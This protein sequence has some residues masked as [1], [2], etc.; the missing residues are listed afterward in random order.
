[1]N[2][3]R[4]PAALITGA[5][6]GLGYSMSR[7]LARRG[8]DL[9]LV[10]LPG[11]G[12][13]SLCQSLSRSYSIRAKCIEI[14]MISA[15]APAR[16]K[17]IT[18]SE[19]TSI[20]ILINNVGIGYGGEI[21]TYKTKSVEETFFLN[22]ISATLMTN[23][24][25]DDLKSF[26]KSH[27]LNMGSFSGFTPMPYKSMY[28]AS[29]AYIFNFSISVREELHG[30]GVS[31]SVAMPGPVKTNRKVCERIKSSGKGAQVTALEADEAAKEIISQMFRGRRVI[32]PGRAYKF[33][34][35]VALIIPYGLVML[36][37]R[38]TF[39]GID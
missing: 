38:N 22:M 11:T 3:G 7:E 1:M 9:V 13:E 8:H 15:E 14:D 34:H 20:N 39:K 4:K 12:L 6:A 30:T 17:E 18:D 31:V 26:P 19:G 24:F 25:I 33:L 16:I 29:K 23:M 2:S 28:S 21:G 36:M 32:V 10:A 35:T 5:S 37:T 27:I